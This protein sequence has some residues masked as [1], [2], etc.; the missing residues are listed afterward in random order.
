VGYQPFAI[1]PLTSGVDQS[2]PSQF[3]PDDAYQSLDNVYVRRGVL[4]KRQGY[5]LLFQLPTIVTTALINITDIT[6]ASV[7]VVTASGAVNGTLI[8]I[9]DVSGMTEVNFAGSNVYVVTNTTPTNFELFDL[10]GSPV[11]TTAYSSYVSSG[12]ITPS[13]T[14]ASATKTD[15]VVVTTTVNHGLSNGAV[16]YI[17]GAVSMSIN[18][19]SYVVTNKTLN[20]FELYY[21]DGQPVDGVDFDDYT[22]L[23]IISTFVADDIITGILKFFKADGSQSILV[24][25]ERF[26]AYFDD[27]I[28]NLVPV[29]NT[30]LFFGSGGDFFLGDTF[31]DKVY[32]TNNI[33]NIGEWSI[34]DNKLSFLVPKYGSGA[35]DLIITCSQIHSFKD[36]LLLLSPTQSGSSPGLQA[37]RLT[38]SALNDV[39]SVNAWRY[40]IPGKGFFIDASVGETLYSSC[41]FKDVII[42]SFIDSLWRI[43][44]TASPSLPFIW[45]RIN[46]FRG[47][48]SRKSLANT[49]NAIM[50]IGQEGV[51]LCDGVNVARVDQKIPTFVYDAIDQEFFYTVYCERDDILRQVWWTYPKN[52]YPKGSALIFGEDDTN[53]SNYTLPFNVLQSFETVSSDTTWGFY[54]SRNGNDWAWDEFPEDD[55]WIS[56]DMQRGSPIFVAGTFDGRVVIVNED[57]TDN[58]TEIEVEIVTKEFNPFFA[59]G[60]KCRLGYVDILLEYDQQMLFYVDFYTNH[61]LNAYVTRTVNCIPKS[62]DPSVI[63]VLTKRIW[64]G[65]IGNSHRFRL[66]TKGDAGGLRI[67]SVTPYFQAA[68]GRLYNA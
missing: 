16:I 50:G 56:G 59:Q 40:D 65:C 8:Q 54:N 6:R 39:L 44:A 28:S 3:I 43:R 41:T 58:G 12:V 37:Q 45:E 68:G 51:F 64:A 48:Q 22:G 10:F 32:F 34:P 31:G 36:R 46:S 26:M 35:T 23:G 9:A 57:A 52:G 47:V 25:T 66:Y 14:I 33:D 55:S 15:P 62:N 53:Y 27:T 19:T 17:T 38:A 29:S 11:N 63:T 2:L 5:T 20:T 4:Q 18:G 1:A 67:Q 7:G 24:F 61:S 49:H 42:V 30:R 60:K 13:L 21:K